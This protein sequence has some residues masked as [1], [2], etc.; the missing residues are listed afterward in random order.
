MAACIGD[1]IQRNAH[2][3]VHWAYL[4]VA[5]TIMIAVLAYLGLSQS[6]S[7]SLVLAAVCLRGLLLASKRRTLQ[8]DVLR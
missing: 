8:H 5:I 6:L 1:V 4:A 3:T 7:A 2:V